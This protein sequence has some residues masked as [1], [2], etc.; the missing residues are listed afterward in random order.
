MEEITMAHIRKIISATVRKCEYC[1]A[2][3]EAKTA[4]IEKPYPYLLSGVKDVFLVGIMVLSCPACGSESPIIPKMADLHRAIEITLM[5]KK[6]SLRGDEIR[7]L[8]KNAGFA[9]QD[10]AALLGITPSHLSRIENGKTSK[11]GS[12]A[13]RLARI[14]AKAHIAG[15][16][17]FKTLQQIASERVLA[18]RE[19]VSGQRELFR[20]ERNRWHREKEAA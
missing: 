5:Q 15:E 16:V 10:F 11:L 19:A 1:S 2:E 6:E 17:Q 8:R 12:S 18:A 20:L 4:T 14:V 3:M 9:A 13:D 7:F